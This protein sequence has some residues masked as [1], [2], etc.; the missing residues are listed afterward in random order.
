MQKIRQFFK[1]TE[2]S[3]SFVLKRMLKKNDVKKSK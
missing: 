3:T 2:L 1:Q